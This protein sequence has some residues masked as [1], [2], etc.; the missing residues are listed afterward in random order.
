MFTEN[1]LEEQAKTDLKS[2]F[3]QI[4]N[5]SFQRNKVFSDKVNQDISRIIEQ[6]QKT[7]GQ[8]TILSLSSWDTPIL[9]KSFFSKKITIHIFGIGD[10]YWIYNGKETA[11][12][13][14]IYI[15]E[16]IMKGTKLE[17]RLTYI[18]QGNR[19]ILI[20][21]RDNNGYELGKC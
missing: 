17:F 18:P 13:G 2:I 15:D 11:I 7:I 10:N 19:Y 3:Q 8:K 5:Q 4:T 14:E 9:K 12:P 6:D 20:R 16:G 1:N 21:Y